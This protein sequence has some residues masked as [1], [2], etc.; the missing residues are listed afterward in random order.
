MST[1]IFN[2]KIKVAPSILSADFS[3]LGEEIKFLDSSNADYIHIDVMDAYFVPNLAISPVV[4]SAIRPYTKKIFDVHL[5]MQY[6]HLYIKDFIEAGADIIAI[7][8]ECNTDQISL[9][10]EIR[11]LGLKSC[12]VYNPDSSIDNISD[13]FPFVDQILFMSVYPGFGGQKLIQSC[14]KKGLTVRKKIDNSPYNI[15]L[16]IDGG[17]KPD[18]AELVRKHGFNILV[19]GT[20]VF[21]AKDRNNA[22]QLLKSN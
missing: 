11:S 4:I 13:Y 22:I 17:V 21:N 5:M 14:L 7:H 1:E 9:L 18:N 12:I 16:E 8:H 10:K 2:F 20:G 6:P 19:S 15:D 3:K